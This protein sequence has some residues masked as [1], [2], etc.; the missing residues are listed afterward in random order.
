MHVRCTYS[1]FLN[2][3]TCCALKIH[4]GTATDIRML[5][6]F[7][8]RLRRSS[9][10]TSSVVDFARNWNV[11]NGKL[12]RTLDIDAQQHCY[13]VCESMCLV[14]HSQHDAAAVAAAADTDVELHFPATPH[15]YTLRNSRI[16]TFQLL[17]SCHG[18]ET[19]LYLLP[20]SCLLYLLV[21]LPR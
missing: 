10:F 4:N 3:S 11:L 18:N 7:L 8:L 5:L 14:W 16:I 19:N 2:C 6:V 15:E 13:S 20:I 12:H 17:I 21:C 1:T 9:V